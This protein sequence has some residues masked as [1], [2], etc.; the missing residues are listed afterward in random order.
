MALAGMQ[1]IGTRFDFSPR[2]AQQ[3]PK[4]KL[5]NRRARRARALAGVS[6]DG[7]GNKLAQKAEFGLVG[8]RHG[9]TYQQRYGKL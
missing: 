1:N 8:L 3:G 7:L 4:A 6:N 5:K 2:P 9:Q